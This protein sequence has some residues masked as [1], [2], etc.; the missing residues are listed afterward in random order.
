MKRRT[1][2]PALFG[3]ILD[4]SET[5]LPNVN[6]LRISTSAAA[7][8]A[9]ISNAAFAEAVYHPPGP[10]LTYGDVAHGQRLQSVSSNP[11]AAAADLARGDERRT[12]GVSVSAV[13]GVE[14]GNI[15][16]IFDF[17]DRVSNGY[18]PSDPG[19]GGGGP[20]Q[21]PDDKP[22]NGIDLG[23]IWDNL[24]PDVQNAL[25]AVAQ[26]VVVQSALLSVIRN[27]GYARA[28]LGADIPF[29]FGNEFLGGAWTFGLGYSGNSK[30]FGVVDQIE[31]DRDSARIALEEWFNT[32]VAN[33]P[34][35][36]ELSSNVLLNYDAATNGV[37]V[38]IKNDSSIVSKSTRLSEV[39]FGYS[40]FVWGNEH[41]SLFLGLEA[42]VYAMGLSRLS[43]RFG[44]ITDSNE[45]FDQIRTADF[46]NDTR[47]GLD[48]G[49]LWVA[50]NYQLGVQVTN[51]NEPKFQ[52]PDVN[53]GPYT[54][55]RVIDFLQQ[56]QTY[57]MDRQLKLEGSIFT[58]DRRWSAHLGVAVDPATDALGDDYQ[59]LTASVGYTN[60]GWWVP[61]VRLGL[62]ENL[63]G[64]RR[65]YAALGATFFK[66]VNFDIASSFDTVRIDG[67]DL[68]QGLMASIGFQI[69]W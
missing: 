42:H 16:N 25:E 29:Q 24:D 26:E 19:S 66:I 33:R 7:V 40:D 15:D 14:Y 49:A 54:S 30:A 64:T 68:P 50:E 52:F 20:G 2:N 55:Q 32:L 10:N 12:R 22:G 5:I 63:A 21:D 8:A 57:K 59:W 4:C 47:L 51:S 46:R 27:E 3:I 56:D 9:L 31:F 45:L 62:R 48:I 11:A 69:S 36:I 58:T 53:L 67:Q 60:E 39:N 18:E 6:I 61:S 37:S 34:E 65:R 23:E 13:A 1:K 17:I 38:R 28:W 35:I 43:V 41:G 44:D